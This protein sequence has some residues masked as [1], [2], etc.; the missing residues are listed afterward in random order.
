[1]ESPDPLRQIFCLLKGIV[2]ILHRDPAHIRP[3][4]LNAAAELQEPVRRFKDGGAEPVVHRKRQLLRPEPVLQEKEHILPGA[5]PAVDHLVG[6]ADSK[7]LRISIVS[8]RCQEIKLKQIAVLHLVHNDPRRP[9]DFCLSLLLHAEQSRTDFQ[10][11]RKGHLILPPLLSLQQRIEPEEIILIPAL[12]LSR[13]IR[14]PLLLQPLLQAVPVLHLQPMLRD[15]VQRQICLL[16]RIHDRELL[17]PARILHRKPVL[18]QPQGNAVESAEALHLFLRKAGLP[19]EK[20]PRDLIRRL[21]GK[22]QND[23]L[24]QRHLT[25]QMQ[26]QDLLDQDRGLPTPHIGV[27]HA[28]RTFIQDR[29]LLVFI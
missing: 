7:K 8:E 20:P 6:I 1:M 10:Q 15:N 26:I 18:Q 23:H 9:P 21:V 29:R 12:R 27:H 11:I 16:V 19:P 25:L 2:M 22:C 13:Q 3:A 24:L 17:R 28:R 4:S 14:L 5:P